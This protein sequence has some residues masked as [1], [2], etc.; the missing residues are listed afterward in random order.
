MAVGI[1]LRC[2][3]WWGLGASRAPSPGEGG[4]SAYPV[5]LFLRPEGP[6]SVGLLLV[7]DLCPELPQLPPSPYPGLALGAGG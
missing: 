3:V 6:A 1:I 2:P 5:C 7:L 4:S